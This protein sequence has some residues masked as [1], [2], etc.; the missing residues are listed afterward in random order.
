MARDRSLD[1][2]VSGMAGRFPGSSELTQWWDALTAGQVL[3]RRYQRQEL[4]SEGVPRTCST[5]RTTWRCTATSLTP[6]GS[7]TCCSG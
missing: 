4:A 1:I 7:T 6:T 2:A 3:T 5:T